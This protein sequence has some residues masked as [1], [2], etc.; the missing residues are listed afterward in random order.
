MLGANFLE[1]LERKAKNPEVLWKDLDQIKSLKQEFIDSID[2]THI[3]IE[4]IDYSDE[5]LVFLKKKE[6]AVNEKDSLKNV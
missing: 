6:I 4:D 3:D 5:I 1:T 2:L